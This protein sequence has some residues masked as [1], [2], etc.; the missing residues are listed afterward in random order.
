[1]SLVPLN[2]FVNHNGKAKRQ[3]ITCGYK[4]GDA[5]SKPVPNRSDNEYFG[6]IAK[7]VSRRSMLQVGGVAVLAVGA[8]SVLAACSSDTQPAE[9]SASSA[10]PAEPP[11]GMNFP[12]VPPNSEDAVVIP[13]GY[14]QGL[15]ISW[16]DPILPGAPKF[17]VN[18]QTG[19]GQRG[20]LVGLPVKILQNFQRQ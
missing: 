11:A 17:D 14:Q 19:A 12:S 16:G 1:M 4:C 10:A 7:A 9:T 15:V 6:D 2:L 8:G 20:Q 3:H 13:E 18:N 5:C